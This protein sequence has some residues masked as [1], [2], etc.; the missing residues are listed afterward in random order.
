MKQANLGEKLKSLRLEF[1][2]TQEDIASFLG[3]DQSLISKYEK[4]ERNISA[5]ALEKLG[6]LYGCNLVNNNS[7]ETAPIKIAYRTSDICSADM[8]AICT[9]NRVVLNSLLMSKL[10]EEI[11]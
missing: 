8:E 7:F 4:N 10:L 9:I 6:D 11:D 1:G 3:V 2:Y 5:D